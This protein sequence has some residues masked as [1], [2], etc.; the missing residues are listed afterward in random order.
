MP[1][2]GFTPGLFLHMVNRR[3]KGLR[4]L[5]GLGGRPKV[6]YSAKSMSKML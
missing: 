1:R 3:A 4:P 2:K 6:I 5:R